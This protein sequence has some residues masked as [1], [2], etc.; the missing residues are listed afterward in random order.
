MKGNRLF[1]AVI[2][3]MAVGL[4]FYAIDAKGLWLDEALSWRLQDFP[5]ALMLERTGEPS[6]VHPPLYFALLHA[7]TSCFGDSE[8]ALRSFSALAGVLTV[9]AT[10]VLAKDLVKLVGD[11]SWKSAY[12]G[13][14][15]VGLLAAALVAFSPFHVYLARQVRGYALGTFLFVFCSWALV[16]GL[17]AETRGSA[18]RFWLGYAILALAFCYTH[19]LAIFS[20]AA[21]GVFAALYFFNSYGQSQR[22]ARVVGMLDAE[23]APNGLAES[24]P[25]KDEALV[26]TRRR[27]AAIALV[28]LA[29]GYVPWLSHL[30][31]QSE[32]VRTSWTE[33]QDLE[34]CARELYAAVLATSGVNPKEPIG[35][36]WAVTFVLVSVLGYVGARFGW[37]GIFLLLTGVIPVWLNLNYSAFS[38]RSIFDAR[39][40]AFAQVAWLIAFAL[41]ASSLSSRFARA[42]AAAVLLLVTASGLWDNWLLLGPESHPGVR[43]AVAHIDEQREESEAV[44]ALTPFVFFQ[45]AYY[46]RGRTSPVLCVHTADRQLQRGAAQ[47]LD[48]DLVT[49][50]QVLGWGAGGLWVVTSDSYDSSVET[51]LSLPTVWRRVE[52]REFAAETHIPWERSVVVTHY[53]RVR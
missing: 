32:A 53:R 50:H 20:V 5:L 34:C 38:M 15:H 31:A 21:H 6:T 45:M 10:C 33:T 7:W 37:A 47:L 30:W 1:L 40:L 8:V 41:A 14:W 43:G 11:S 24:R 51:R 39:Y 9:L 25:R 29:A 16:R 46:M 49:P 28:L 4:R 44:I 23:A 13:P 17:R 12:G 27:C 42:L 26:A 48:D 22:A 19:H 18:R 2:V 3:V 52:Q 35:L 36:S